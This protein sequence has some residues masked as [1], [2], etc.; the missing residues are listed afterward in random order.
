MYHHGYGIT[1]SNEAAITWYELSADQGF[2]DAKT[3]LFYIKCF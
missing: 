2:A 1:Q 3:A